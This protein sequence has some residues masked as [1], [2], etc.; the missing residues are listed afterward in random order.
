MA[1][2]QFLFHSLFRS[3]YQEKPRAVDGLSN[4]NQGGVFDLLLTAPSSA[5]AT[6][7]ALE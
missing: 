4:A 5:I 2:I 1:G 7:N 3:D 6:S